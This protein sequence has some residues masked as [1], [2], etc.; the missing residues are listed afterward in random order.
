MLCSAVA[1]PLLGKLGD[2]RGH[3][4]IFLAG[5]VLSTAAA[6]A[7]ALAW[8]VTS[9]I[10]IRT[11]AAA[12]G[13]DGLAAVATLVSVDPASAG[14]SMPNGCVRCHDGIEDMHPEAGLSCVDCHGGDPEGRTTFQAHVHS[15]LA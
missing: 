11:L 13:A 5:F 8:D 12:V 1:L 9:L 3:R 6:G 7:T 2:L 14:A 10:G 4:R 15:T